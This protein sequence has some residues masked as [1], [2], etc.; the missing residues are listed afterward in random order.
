MSGRSLFPCSIE[1]A[2]RLA[3]AFDGDLRISYSGGADIFNIKDIFKA[4][5]WPITL[6][7]TLLKP[8]GY[9]RLDQM[10]EDLVSYN[11]KEVQNLKPSA[12][13]ML[14]KRART[15]PHNRCV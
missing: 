3:K 14:A 5:V 2:N 1:L 13:S 4:G 10:A 15:N 6:A 8:G 9:N 11:F 12:L 7:T